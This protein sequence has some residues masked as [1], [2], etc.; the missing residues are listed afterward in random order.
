MENLGRN[1]IFVTLP[2]AIKFTEKHLISE[3]IYVGIVEKGHLFAIGYFAE[4][5]LR[6]PTNYK[7]IVELIREKKDSCAQNATRN[8]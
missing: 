2:V 4:K 3:P 8:S 5:D 7:G 6:D 1:N